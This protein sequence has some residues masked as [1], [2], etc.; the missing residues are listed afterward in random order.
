MVSFQVRGCYEAFV[1][2]RIEGVGVICVYCGN[3]CY[4]KAITSMG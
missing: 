2:G 3:Q 4:A 1:K